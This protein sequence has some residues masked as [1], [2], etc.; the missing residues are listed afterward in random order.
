MEKLIEKLLAINSVLNVSISSNFAHVLLVSKN[1]IT[2][3]T[4]HEVTA[5]DEKYTIK[6]IKN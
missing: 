4:L 3:E 1:E 2:T 5:Y 6:K